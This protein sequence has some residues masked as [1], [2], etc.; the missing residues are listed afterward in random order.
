MASTDC[1]GKEGVGG[2][3]RNLA[4]LR[5]KL[6]MGERRRTEPVVESTAAGGDHSTL[7]RSQSDRTEYG[8]KLQGTGPACLVLCCWGC[9]WLG[10]YLDTLQAAASR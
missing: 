8:Q 3:R 7:R 10:W 4:L 9:S 1:P 6:Y 2:R 5:N